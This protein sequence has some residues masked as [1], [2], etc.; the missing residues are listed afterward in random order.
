VLLTVENVYCNL[1]F[2]MKLLGVLHHMGA[3]E[4]HY[5]IKI[6]YLIKLKISLCKTKHTGNYINEYVFLTYRFLSLISNIV[7]IT[8]FCLEDTYILYSTPVSVYHS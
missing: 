6:L 3:V 1:Q 7:C 4:P 5:R 2:R 8:I